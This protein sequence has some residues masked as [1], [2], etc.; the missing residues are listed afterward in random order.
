L[1]ESEGNMLSQKNGDSMKFDECHS[2][3]Y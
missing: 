3:L 2:N 1:R